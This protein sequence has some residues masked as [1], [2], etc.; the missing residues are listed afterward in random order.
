MVASGQLHNLV[1]LPKGHS[2]HYPKKYVTEGPFE[3]LRAAQL[4][5]KCLIFYEN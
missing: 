5:I 4:V 1:A 2:P 3:K